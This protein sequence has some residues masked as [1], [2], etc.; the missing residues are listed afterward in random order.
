MAAK[1][2]ESKQALIITLVVFVILSIILAITT[3]LGF[4]GQKAFETKEKE[5]KADKTKW[6]KAADWYRFQGLQYRAYM[7]APLSPQEME[8]LGTLRSGFGD[9]T[10]GSLVTG[11]DLDTN[12]TNTAKFIRENLDPRFYDPAT[13]KV[14]D[15]FTN[16]LQEMQAKSDAATKR[17]NETQALLEQTSAKLKETNDTLE[18]AKAD[19][20]AK[21]TALEG[22][23]SKK[24]EGYLADIDRLQQELRQTGENSA[25]VKTTSDQDVAKIKKENDRM[26]K[27]MRTMEDKIKKLE[28]KIPGIDR[29]GLDQ[30]KA[31]VDSLDKLGRLAYINV[32]SADNV[33][34]KLTFR[35]VGASLDGKPGA[36]KGSLEVVQVMGPRQSQARVTEVIDP[37]REPIMVG[38]L[39]YNL[40]WSPTMQKHVAIA[41]VIDLADEG[42]DR[43]DEFVRGLK[44]RGVVVDAYVDLKDQTIKGEI[45]RTTEYLIIGPLPQDDKIKMSKDKEDSY[46]NKVKELTNAA[47]THGATPVPLRE[48]LTLVGFRVPKVLQESDTTSRFGGVGLTPITTST[49][50]KDKEATKEEASTDKKDKNDKGEQQDQE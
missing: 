23:F 28:S 13:K 4:D 26:A 10:D 30:P 20:A 47:K 9:Q 32:G 38:D 43:T 27:T 33:K 14:K 12:R 48:F 39:L 50:G 3:Y 34:P 22:A 21:L 16:Q 2:G 6:E 19:Y 11:A 42:K 15:N 31:K 17:S 1:T 45:T 29:P 18:K 49:N 7:G 40:S 8:A 35:I 24:Q 5:A 25:T 36:E 46:Q 37:N 41:G 44:E